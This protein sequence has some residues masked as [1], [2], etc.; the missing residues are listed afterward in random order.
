MAENAQLKSNSNE[1]ELLRLRGQV[2]PAQA[3]ARELAQLKST[4]ADQTGKMPD[5]L[6]NAL[7]SGLAMAEKFKIKDAQ[8]RFGRMKKMLNLTDDQA[9]AIGD[10]MQKHIQNRDQM[11]MAS[12][13]GNKLTPEQLQAM[14]G[15]EDDETEIKA[16]LTP[17]QLAAYPDYQQEE[18]TTAADNSAK[19]EAG[20]IADDFSLSPE[21]QEQIHAALYQMNLN[22]PDNLNQAAISAAIKSGQTPDVANMVAESQKSQ[23]DEKLK[24]LGNILTPEQL[25]TYRKEQMDKI[26]MLANATK[27]FLPQK[28]AE[29]SN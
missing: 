6:T 18:K 11:L 1:N 15:A 26:N 16:L 3:N 25:N 21:Q 13:S 7:A 24:I 9:Q 23:L 8:A 17:G 4:L 22:E 29:T 2:A 19:D 20:T 5:Y 12:M 27:M 14:A 28:P 10:I